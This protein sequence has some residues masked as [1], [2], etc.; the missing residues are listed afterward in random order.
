MAKPSKFYPNSE[1]HVSQH[2]IEH[3]KTK[4]EYYFSLKGLY[5]LNS[6]ENQHKLRNIEVAHQ[7]VMKSRQHGGLNIRWLFILIYVSPIFITKHF[8]FFNVTPYC[9]I[10]FCSSGNFVIAVK[11]WKGK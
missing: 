8:Y 2:A 9:N 10:L 11:L 5:H 3:N 4:V 7:L 1:R 6:S